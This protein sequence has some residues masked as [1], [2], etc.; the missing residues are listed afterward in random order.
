MNFPDAIKS[1]FLKAFDFK[2]RASRSEYWYTQLFHNIVLFIALGIDV[3]FLGYSWWYDY[4]PISTSATLVLLIPYWAVSFRRYHDLNKS[5]LKFII[6]PYISFYALI[7]FLI[8]AGDTFQ[9]LLSIIMIIGFLGIISYS[10][11]LF[12]ILFF[13]G[14]IGPNKYGPD[15]LENAQSDKPQEDLTIWDENK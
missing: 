13:R 10:L 6:I 1:Y 7:G 12:I 8:F 15:P 4:S 2:S 9:I 5:V 3:Y 14:S 11:Y